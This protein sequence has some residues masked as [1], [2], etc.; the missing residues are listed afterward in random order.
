MKLLILQHVPFEGPAAIKVW[1]EQGC[2]AI[3]QHYCATDSTYP[4]LNSFD[5]LIIMGG[6][7]SVN[8]DLPWMKPELVFINLAIQ[9]NKYIIGICLGAQ[10]IAKALGATVSKHTQ[11]EIGWYTVEQISHDT[12]TALWPASALPTSFTPLHWH[13]DTFS[14]PKGASLLYRSLICENQAFIYSDHV[15]GLQFHLEFDLSTTTRIAKACSDELK[16]GGEFVQ[17]AKNI[18]ADKGKFENANKLMHALLDAMLQ[19]IKRK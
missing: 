7:M 19:Q 1:A 11:A 4:A 13:S 12:N 16:Q 5:C 10:L 3:H 14:I 8:D 15:L 18:M 17:S 9:Q 2:H 6:P